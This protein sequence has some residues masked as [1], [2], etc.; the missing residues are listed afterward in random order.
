MT[1]T[2][3]DPAWEA[4]CAS[5][6][7]ETAATQPRPHVERA[8][9]I[10]FSAAFTPIQSPAASG[11]V[12]MADWLAEADRKMQKDPDGYFKPGI[13]RHC[14]VDLGP[15]DDDK[16]FPIMGTFLPFVCCT[17]CAT[18]GKAKLA[19]EEREAQEMR[20]AGIIPTEFLGWHTGKGN[21]QALATA[22]DLLRREPKKGILLHGE[23]GTCKTRILW[24][25]VR[26]IVELPE[27][28]TWLVLDAFEL[29][30]MPSIPKEAYIVQH[31]FIDDLGN[32]A[33][34]FKNKKRF[35]T[36][37]LHLIRKRND[38]HKATSVTTQLTGKA[39]KE[40]FFSGVT[41]AAILRRWEE[42]MTPVNTS[43]TASKGGNA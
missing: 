19:Q 1:T 14:G 21:N 36:S 5:A 4:A 11:P 25:L 2:L 13:C 24:H 43:A 35:E 37:F 17:S 27:P 30:T 6:D 23:S 34:D 18:A 3:I 28:T 31:L 32:E 10:P 33:E 8:D 16:C 15:N 26:D 40:K 22:R 42:R 20:Y 38:W 41:A 9:P 39:F 12:T 7:A 29:S